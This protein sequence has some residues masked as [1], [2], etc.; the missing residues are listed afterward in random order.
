[1]ISTVNLQHVYCIHSIEMFLCSGA[2]H[3]HNSS[4][5]LNTPIVSLIMNP[6]PHRREE[7]EFHSPIES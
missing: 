3:P 6:G 5:P 7:L 1:M 4:T 2:A